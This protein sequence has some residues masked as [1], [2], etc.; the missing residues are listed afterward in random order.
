MVRP[1]VCRSVYLLA[2]SSDGVVVAVV[3]VPHYPQPSQTVG[4][5]WLLRSFFS[6]V[7]PTPPPPFLRP[8]PVY[9]TK[10]CAIVSLLLGVRLLQRLAMYGFALVCQTALH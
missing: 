8:T 9:T 6:V 5:F 3:G 4:V 1:S 2:F 7:F 10:V